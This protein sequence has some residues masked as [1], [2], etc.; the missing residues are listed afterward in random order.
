MS[1]HE[2]VLSLSQTITGAAD[3]EKPLLE[4]LCSAAEQKWLARLRE[5]VKMSGCTDSL[6][7]AAAFSAAAGLL[8]AR[9][10]GETVSSFTAGNV[11]INLTDAAEKASRALRNQAE[12]LMAPYTCAGEF[13]FRGV[14][15]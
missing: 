13:A 10:G 3:T 5:D 6:V 12:R 7:C 11:A 4:S 9:R 14:R 8:S 15:T 2:Q 1:V